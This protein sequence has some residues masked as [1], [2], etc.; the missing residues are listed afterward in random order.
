M[1]VIAAV[2]DRG[3]CVDRRG[4]RSAAAARSGVLI[5]RRRAAGFRVRREQR[6]RGRAAS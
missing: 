4:L 3:V 1:C 6:L 5:R 2:G